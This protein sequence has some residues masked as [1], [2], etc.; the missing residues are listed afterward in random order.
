MWF[1]N[2]TLFRFSE[3]FTVNESK[4]IEQLETHRF[5]SCGSLELSTYGWSAPLG[6]QSE[7]LLHATG[8][9]WMLCAQKEEKII[10]ASVINELVADKVEEIESEQARQVRKKERD[11]IKEEVIHDCLPKAFSHRRRTFAYIDPKGGWIVVD[12]A[13]AKKAEEVVSLLRKSLGSL[14]V[15]LPAVSEAP[16]VIM[17]QWLMDDATVASD[18]T[19]EAEC[20]LYSPEDDGGIVRCK[21]H[22]LYS[23]EI[24]AHL[25]AGKRVRKLAI[26][27]NDRLTCV[28]DDSLSIKSLRFLDLVQEQAA[29]VE[30][31]GAA[32]QFDADFSIMALEIAAF[33]PRLLELFGG[34]ADRLDKQAA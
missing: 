29:E 18:I 10:P 4:L 22:D 28:L 1:K 34:E 32:E 31:D 6:R 21:K 27:W 17:T 16:E 25:D 26:S 9:Y 24:R 13:T 12:A 19:I 30:A 11:A 5:R 14:P 2:L 20:E 15:E 23:P 33:L 8:G 3:A 7:Q